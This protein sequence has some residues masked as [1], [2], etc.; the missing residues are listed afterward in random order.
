MQEP[1]FPDYI[2]EKEDRYYTFKSNIHVHKDLLYTVKVYLFPVVS[3]F[4][5]R[6]KKE[7][8]EALRSH[9]RECFRVS[10]YVN[11][12]LLDFSTLEYVTT[13]NKVDE[14]FLHKVHY[15]YT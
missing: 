13:L 5:V 2:L 12:D 3:T 9:L 10:K 6:N 14:D 7:E 15:Q 1:I 4:V 11:T 8:K